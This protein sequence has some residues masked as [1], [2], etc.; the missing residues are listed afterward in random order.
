MNTLDLG[1]VHLQVDETIDNF[2]N[3]N[4]QFLAQLGNHLEVHSHHP[5][6]LNLKFITLIVLMKYHTSLINCYYSD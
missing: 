5:L 2:L 1:I 4:L 6:S 3:L